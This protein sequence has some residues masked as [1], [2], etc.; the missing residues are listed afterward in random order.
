MNPALP[1]PQ[2][3]GTSI[4]NT[5]FAAAVLNAF[6][7]APAIFQTRL[8]GLGSIFVNGPA[9]GDLGSCMPN[10]W[11]YRAARDS[12]THIAISA[13]LWGLACPDG[14]AYAYHCFESDLLATLLHWPQSP[15][16]PRYANAN[17]AADNLD[18]T[19]LAALAHEVGH[20]HWYEAMN[21]SH[22]GQGYN[23]NLFCGGVFFTDSW[24][25]P[26][27]RLPPIW[28]GFAERDN[29][30]A[31]PP[32]IVTVDT[33]IRNQDWPNAANALDQLYQPTQP[34]ASFFGALSPDEDFVETYK[35]YVMTNAQSGQI[36]NEGPLTSLPITFVNGRPPND[37]PNTYGI[38]DSAN[39][40]APS[41]TQKSV[42]AR[43]AR[44]IGQTI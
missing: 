28:R 4:A 26:I 44:C 15:A 13:G 1:P 35:L 18:M 29:T 42:L 30:H 7:L 36:A 25:T 37:I 32:Q 24:Q 6:K 8:C 19:I 3:L 22:P 9:C 41:I 11:G 39:F 40:G 23:P 16:P 43:K 2:G 5:A 12:T 10:S 17:A 38:P 31:N 21:P 27:R 14:S 33:F 34:W 20:V